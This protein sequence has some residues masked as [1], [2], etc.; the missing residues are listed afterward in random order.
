MPEAPPPGAGSVSV[1][2]LPSA[3]AAL[4]RRVLAPVLALALAAGCGGGTLAEVSAP[5]AGGGG[6]ERAAEL[7]GDLPPG[8]GEHPDA[9][10]AE[11]PPAVAEAG[12]DL[13]RP[14]WLGTRLL[15][16][17]PDGLGE[18][19]P[20][21]PEL[22]VRRLPTVDH[23]P[24]PPSDEFVATVEP[25]P[26]AVLARSTWGPACPVDVDDLRY[27]TVAFWGFDERPHTGELLVHARVAGGIVEV[28]RR[29]HEARFPIEEMRITTPAELDAH[30]TGDGNN[31][32]SFTC[33]QSRAGSSAWSE[34]AYG[35]AVD[36]N[37]FQNPYVRGDIVLPELASAYVNRD[38]RRPGM[39]H[40]GDVVVQAFAAIGW[41]WGGYW[42]S[43]KDYMH[44]SHNGR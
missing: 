5:S 11:E 25:V 7:A 1:V 30:P 34:H 44:F 18:I 39:I 10:A 23:L 31:T 16:L 6:A 42:G 9:G 22:E 43:A 26:D 28:F 40:A 14:D 29:L 19:Q 37:P 4:A 24:P 12:P 38:W 35:L 32:G 21:P 41:K 8:E 3:A 2:A 20:T 15:P 36:L 13:V 33:R 27:V 17:R